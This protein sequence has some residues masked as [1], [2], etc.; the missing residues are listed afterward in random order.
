MDLNADKVLRAMP[1]LAG[2]LD[3]NRSAP[4]HLSCKYGHLKIVRALLYVSLDMCLAR[5][6]Q[7]RTLLHLAVINGRLDVVRELVPAVPQAVRER[8]SFGETVLHLCVKH[9][10]LEVLTLL[11]NEVDDK[12]ILNGKENEGNTI[13]HLAVADKQVKVWFRIHI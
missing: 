4:L 11:V 2:E 3:S 13:L 12:D 10:Q 1:E 7:G 9:T 8:M 6:L 5:D